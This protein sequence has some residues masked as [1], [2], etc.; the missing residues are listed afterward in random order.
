MKT[1]TRCMLDGKSLYDLSGNALAYSCRNKT[2]KPKGNAAGGEMQWKF[3]GLSF[4]PSA[5]TGISARCLWFHG[6]AEPIF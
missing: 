1:Q 3:D 6:V 5:L 2:A 4:A